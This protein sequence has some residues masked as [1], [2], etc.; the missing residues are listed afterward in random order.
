MLYDMCAQA[1]LG[2]WAQRGG[3]D[4][5]AVLGMQVRAFCL[6]GLRYQGF[7]IHFSKAV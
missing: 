5:G 2:V 3:P 1:E 7:L 6:V 4:T